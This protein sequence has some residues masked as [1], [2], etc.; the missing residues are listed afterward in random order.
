M[1]WLR[2]E[3]ASRCRCGVAPGEMIDDDGRWL[4]PIDAAWEVAVVEC[5]VCRRIEHAQEEL[6]G[7]D[8]R[9]GKRVA[10]RRPDASAVPDP[11]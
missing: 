1:A 7:E 9:A 3:E 5:P 6:R 11:S 8:D 2:E 10:L 4:D